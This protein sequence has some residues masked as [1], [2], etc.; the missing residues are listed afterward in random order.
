MKITGMKEKYVDVKVREE[1]WEA[2][3]KQAQ[4]TG[5][6]IQELLDKR[7]DEFLDQFMKDLK[8]KEN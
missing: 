3:K 5:V 2:L 6:P 1:K 7:F 4:L 8:D